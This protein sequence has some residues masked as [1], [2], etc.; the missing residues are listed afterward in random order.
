MVGLIQYKISMEVATMMNL[1]KEK[2]KVQNLFN[3]A[4]QVGDPGFEK[5]GAV[6][7]LVEEKDRSL[8]KRKEVTI[9]PTSEP[10]HNKLRSKSS[11]IHCD[12]SSHN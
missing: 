12:Q 6:D 10:A 8:A 5:G 1:V 7:Y 2:R 3:S 9:N 4:C 11:D